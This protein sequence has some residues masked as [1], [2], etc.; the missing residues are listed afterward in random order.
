MKAQGPRTRKGLA[1]LFLFVTAAAVLSSALVAATLS[2]APGVPDSVSGP[3]R[4]AIST[5]PEAPRAGQPVTVTAE[6]AGNYLAPQTVTLQYA[7][8]FALVST[9]NFPM[10]Y[11]AHR[12]YESTIGPFPDG[13]EVWVVIAASGPNGEPLLSDSYTFAVGTVPRGGPS[14][15]RITDVRHTPTQPE[16]YDSYL[17][18]DATVASASPVVG[19]DL[20]YMAFCPNRRPIGIDPPMSPTAPTRYTITFEMPQECAYQSGTILLYRVLAVDASGNTAVSDV[21]TVH[22]ESRGYAVP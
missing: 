10:A 15:L 12:T 4:Y 7:T 19:V 9:A 18:V 20:A 11:V 17:T 8:Y 2:V 3:L 6:L 14:G 22:V 16:M 1:R 5:S 13:T 21:T